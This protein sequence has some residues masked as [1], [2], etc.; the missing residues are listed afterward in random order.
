MTQDEAKTVVGI[1]LGADNAS[2]LVERFGEEFPG[3]RSVAR[4]WYV[5][6]YGHEHIDPLDRLAGHQKPTESHQEIT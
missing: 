3:Y 2:V 5:R 1:M 6:R 4:A